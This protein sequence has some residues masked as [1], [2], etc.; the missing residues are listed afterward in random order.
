MDRLGAL[1]HLPLATRSGAAG[2]LYG[3]ISGEDVK[4]H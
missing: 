4:I 3:D 1:K 2:G